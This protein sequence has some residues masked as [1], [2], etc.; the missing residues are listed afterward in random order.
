M[1]TI[2]TKQNYLL[3]VQT[4]SQVAFFELWTFLDVM[5]FTTPQHLNPLQALAAAII[6]F[7][8]LCS[9]LCKEKERFC[10]RLGHSTSWPLTQQ[11]LLGSRT[12]PPFHFGVTSAQF[13]PN[14][15]ACRMTVSSKS[16]EGFRYAQVCLHFQ[17]I[18]SQLGI[19]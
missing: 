17:C 7:G 3:L 4:F 15:H 10:P 9:L 16:F 13:F 18:E 6:T 12:S 5:R 19:L 2:I 8:L 14:D 11:S 1:E